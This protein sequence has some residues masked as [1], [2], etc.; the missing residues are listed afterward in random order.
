MKKN[1]GPSFQNMNELKNNEILKKARRSK[2]LN[3][4]SITINHLSPIRIENNFKDIE[5]NNQEKCKKNLKDLV[6][7]FGV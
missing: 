1:D 3:S 2:N 5:R 4:G 6:Y 7:E